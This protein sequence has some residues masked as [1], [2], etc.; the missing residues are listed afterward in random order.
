MTDREMLWY[1]IEP[2]RE[3]IEGEDNEVWVIGWDTYPNHSVLAG[4][5]RKNRMGTMPESEAR[6]KYGEDVRWNNKFLEPQVSV[7]HLPDTPDW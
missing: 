2:V 5:Y 3:Y 6:A 7:A 1:E 4:Q